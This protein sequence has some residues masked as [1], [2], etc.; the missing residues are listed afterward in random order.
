ML[1]MMTSKSI[2]QNIEIDRET[3]ANMVRADR[4]CDTLR[5]SYFKQVEV[6]DVLIEDNELMFKKFN[7]ARKEK[8]AYQKQLDEKEKA[9]NKLFQK[10]NTG[11]LIPALIGVTGGFILATSL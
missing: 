8:E 1:L 9:Y 3:F 6:L 10:P 2:S 7:E 11:W 5:A 4:K